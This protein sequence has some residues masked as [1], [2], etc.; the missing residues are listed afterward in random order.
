M[1]EEHDESIATEN[2]PVTHSN[3]I[4]EGNSRLNLAGKKDEQ[5]KEHPRPS[6]KDAEI[7]GGP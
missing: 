2:R 1:D 5:A 3:T 4:N 7:T 6:F